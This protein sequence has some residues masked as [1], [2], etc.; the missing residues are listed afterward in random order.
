MEI[1]LLPPGTQKEFAKGKAL[2]VLRAW[3]LTVTVSR[4]ALRTEIPFPPL[5]QCL[6]L[7]F[8]PHPFSGC[9][10]WYLTNLILLC[11]ICRFLVLAVI[12]FFFLSFFPCLIWFIA[13]KHC[14]KPHSLFSGL[15]THLWCPYLS[16]L[17]GQF[18]IR[19]QCLLPL[20]VS[21][22]LEKHLSFLKR[23]FSMGN[24]PESI[25]SCFI[26]RIILAFFFNNFL[27]SCWVLY[28]SIL[29]YNFFLGAKPFW[30]HPSY[31]FPG[32]T[33]V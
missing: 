32:R 13:L 6:L 22:V 16:S 28:S 18:L 21:P 26:Q 12:F 17:L 29:L 4:E 25:L 27:L 11:W 33:N 2:Q 5:L 3:P 14:W 8:P 1:Q 9:W 31:L 24:R 23:W 30:Y 10:K 15:W 7:A 19:L 20:T